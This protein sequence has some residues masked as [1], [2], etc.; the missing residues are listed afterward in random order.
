MSG[1]R[2]TWADYK[3]HRIGDKKPEPVK[4]NY[5]TLEEAEARKASLKIAGVLAVITPIVVKREPVRKRQTHL[6]KSDA[7]F[8]ADWKMHR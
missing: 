5:A 8:N 3:A 2:V 7:P 1:Y 4:E 6:G